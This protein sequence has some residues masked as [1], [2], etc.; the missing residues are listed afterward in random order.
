MD[1]NKTKSNHR[2]KDKLAHTKVI[3]EERNKRKDL[4]D[5]S[6]HKRYKYKRKA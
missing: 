4:T 3:L 5:S 1:K 2:D 6:E